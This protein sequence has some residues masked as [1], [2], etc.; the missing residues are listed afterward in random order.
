MLRGLREASSNWIGKTI[1]WAVVL[2]LIG[3]FGIWG[4]GDMFRVSSRAPVATIGSTEITGD[5]FR[6]IFNDRLQQFSR[7]VGRPVT[8]TQARAIGFDQQLLGQ[9][10]GEAALDES[11]QK[12]GLNVSVA[13]LAK[14]VANDQAF[15]GI[16]GEFDRA[17]FDATLRQAG[18]TEQRFFAEQRKVYMRRQLRAR[19]V[20]GHR[21]AEECERSIRA[22]RRR[23]AK[24]RL[25]HAHRGNCWRHCATLAGGTRKIFRGS[26][27]YVPC[28]GVSQ[29]RRAGADAG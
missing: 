6:Q 10:I 18:Y 2:T 7:Q 23:N 8:P 11:T 13:E 5:Q 16:T 19:F 1:M 24:Y 25:C 17:R 29:A 20:G 22:L 3:A 12:L 4:I 27:D 9:L 14:R 26:Q 28:T 21:D 15:R